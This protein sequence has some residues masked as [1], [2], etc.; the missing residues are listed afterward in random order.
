MPLSKLVGLAA[1]LVP[2]YSMTCSEGSPECDVEDRTSLLQ[3]P[4]R[5]HSTY[6]YTYETNKTCGGDLRWFYHDQ[7]PENWRPAA[8]VDGTHS[9]DAPTVLHGCTKLCDWLTDRY[10]RG[11]ENA[12]CVQVAMAWFPNDD[13]FQG[14]YCGHCYPMA[15]CQ[16]QDSTKMD[17]WKDHLVLTAIRK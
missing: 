6:E 2:V 3:V 7:F 15:E 11:L 8:N 9:R 10:K 16:L 12:E 13:S 17:F 14:P 4:V 1:A 5:A